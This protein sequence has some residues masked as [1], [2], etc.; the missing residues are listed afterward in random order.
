MKVEF[1]TDESEAVVLAVKAT[2]FFKARLNDF[3]LESLDNAVNAYCNLYCLI[4]G[5]NRESYDMC[6]EV[7][8]KGDVVIFAVKVDEQNSCDRWLEVHLSRNGIRKKIASC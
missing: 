7:V 6:A 2:E 4:G 3:E 8:K 1:L 5:I